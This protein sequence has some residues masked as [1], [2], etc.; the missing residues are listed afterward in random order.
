MR[1]YIKGGALVLFFCIA[2]QLIVGIIVYYSFSSWEIR[3][4]G[5]MFG[6]TSSL[7]SALA[8][9]CLSFALY[10]QIKLYEGQKNENTISIRNFQ[11]AKEQQDKI[12][13]ILSSQVKTSELSG[14]LITSC[15]L[16]DH[17]TKEQNRLQKDNSILNKSL[18]EKEINENL[19][20]VYDVLNK[21]F[22]ILLNEKRDISIKNM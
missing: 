21:N 1:K 13:Q 14:L 7:F 4:C 11:I 17:Y 9:A 12:S 18:K 3:A 15:Y 22:L 16:I 10:V 19:D 6:I 8:F 2:L 20:L 5:A